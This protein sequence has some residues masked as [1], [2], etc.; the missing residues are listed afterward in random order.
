MQPVFVKALAER[1]HEHN[2]HTALDTSGFADWKIIESLLPLI[3][4][5]LYDLKLMDN[6]RHRQYTAVPNH[7]I[8]N[9]LKE[10]SGHGSRIALRMPLIAGINDDQENISQMI[11]FLNGLPQFESLTLM[12]YHT[13]GT[14]KY[15]ALGKINPLPDAEAPDEIIINSIRQQFEQAG[16]RTQL[17]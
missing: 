16:I 4:L 12:R 3:D 7:N 13:I 10:I 1:C 9:N 6:D 15:S 14:G 17:L 2:V 5:F 8:L 11:K